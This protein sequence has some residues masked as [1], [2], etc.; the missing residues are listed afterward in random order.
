MLVF[1]GSSSCC[2]GVKRSPSKLAVRLRFEGRGEAERVVVVVVILRA[3][4]CG[5]LPA[6]CKLGRFVDV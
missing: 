6:G 2:G 1:S 3:L 4:F 5:L